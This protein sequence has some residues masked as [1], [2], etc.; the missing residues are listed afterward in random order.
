MTDRN[1][2]YE[3]ETE[4]QIDDPVERAYAEDAEIHRLEEGGLPDG[5]G[6]AIESAEQDAAADPELGALQEQFNERLQESSTLREEFDTITQTQWSEYFNERQQ[7]QDDVHGIRETWLRLRG[8]ESDMF[9]EQ[10]VAELDRI[11]T[12]LTELESEMDSLKTQVI[13]RRRAL[14]DYHPPKDE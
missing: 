11:T 1:R 12:R 13:E 8:T 6:N 2:E 10:D 4:E 9:S 3:E 7:P 5:M 14:H